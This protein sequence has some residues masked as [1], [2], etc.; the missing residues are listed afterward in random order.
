M[1][2]EIPTTGSARPVSAPSVY[3]SEID[4]ALQ[5]LAL[6][7]FKELI[8]GNGLKPDN[9]KITKF[10]GETLEFLAINKL[11][12][13]TKTSK[14]RKGGKHP[15][16][17]VLG[18]PQDVQ[19]AIAKEENKILHAQDLSMRIKDVILERKDIGI[20]LE[21]ELIKHGAIYSKGADWSSHTQ[22]DG[23][24]ITGQ[25]PA[26]SEAIAKLLLASLQEKK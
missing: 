13:K 7:R 19:P 25:N 22:Q 15:G 3:R 4:P 5:D 8:K 26:S 20:G 11:E 23:L 17:T 10:S 21:D 1:S 9:T 24:L 12:L 18:G 6:A 2:D 14:T 16:S